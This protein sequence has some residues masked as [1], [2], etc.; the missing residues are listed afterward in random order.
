MPEN[1]QKNVRA[2]RLLLSVPLTP[3]QKDE[4][5]SRA[6]VK[7]VSAYARELLFP[8]NDNKPKRGVRRLKKREEFAASVLAQLGKGEAAASLREISRGVRLGV[9]I[10]TPETDTALREAA[11]SI[12]AAAQAALRAL[13]VKHR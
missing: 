9:I 3:A 1:R 4:L 10:V 7:P 11:E 5:L 6:G 2:P 12:T 13:G 8:A